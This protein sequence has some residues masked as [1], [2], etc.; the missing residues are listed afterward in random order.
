MDHRH[1]PSPVIP[2]VDSRTLTHSMTKIHFFL[3]SLRSTEISARVTNSDSWLRRCGNPKIRFN[4]SVTFWEMYLASPSRRQTRRRTTHVLFRS[5]STANW[6]ASC[7]RDSVSCS[8]VCEGGPT[9]PHSILPP[10]VSPPPS[11]TRRATTTTT[12]TSTNTSST[13]EQLNYYR[14]YTTTIPYTLHL[15]ARRRNVAVNTTFFS[16][17]L[18]FSLTRRQTLKRSMRDSGDSSRRERS[19]DRKR[20][21][22][23]LALAL[24]PVIVVVCSMHR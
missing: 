22:W 5:Q 19:R 6:F 1:P 11:V 13:T 7:T 3:S 8:Y 10:P 14:L 18:F 15:D 20:Q 2:F 24:A 21:R 16:L 4:E 17:F 9:G 12:T 23:R